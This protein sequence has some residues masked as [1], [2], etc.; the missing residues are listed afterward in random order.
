MICEEEI[1][2]SL[3]ELILVKIFLNKVKKNG[4]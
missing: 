3:D 1:S 4:I 2:L